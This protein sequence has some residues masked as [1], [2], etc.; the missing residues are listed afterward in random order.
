[1]NPALEGVRLKLIRAQHHL[2]D[3][4]AVIDRLVRKQGNVVFEEDLETNQGAIRLKLPLPDT[5]LPALIGDFLYNVRSALDHFVYQLAGKPATGSRTHFPICSSKENFAEELRRHRLDNVPTRAQ[6]LIERLQPYHRGN[7]ILTA[8]SELHDMDKHRTINII[9]TLAD[10]VSLELRSAGRRIL[11][12]TAG[13]ELRH[14]AA[15]GN[16]TI[17]LSS[18]RIANI[19]RNMK[20][21]GQ[22]SIFVAFEDFPADESE[23]RGRVDAILQEMLDFVRD[24]VFGTLEPFFN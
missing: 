22:V 18:E 7:E 4:L 17:D 2:D 8:L 12:D 1:M 5:D 24:E 3:V 15:L 16:L 11:F 14:D 21:Q 10:D 9:T 6:T 13:E 19:L 23:P 20:V